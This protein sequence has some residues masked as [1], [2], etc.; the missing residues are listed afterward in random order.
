M[1]LDEDTGELWVGPD[2]PFV[3]GDQ[4]RLGGGP[5]AIPGRDAALQVYEGGCSAHEVFW[6]LKVDADGP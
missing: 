1:R 5:D 3:D 6:T 4:V 2:G